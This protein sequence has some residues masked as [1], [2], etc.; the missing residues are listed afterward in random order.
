MAISLVL[1]SMK[2]TTFLRFLYVQAQEGLIHGKGI[3]FTALMKSGALLTLELLAWASVFRD[4]VQALL[5]Q[6]VAAQEKY[7]RNMRSFIIGMAARRAP[8]S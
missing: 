1:V 8:H 4:V 7:P 2:V 6:S 5:T 3:H